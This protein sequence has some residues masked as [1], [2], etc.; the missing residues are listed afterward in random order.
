MPSCPSF[1]ARRPFGHGRGAEAFRARVEKD[2]KL[3]H[4][5]GEGGR[6][7]LQ[8]APSVLAPVSGAYSSNP[9]ERILALGLPQDR[10]RRR[11]T[12]KHTVP[13]SEGSAHHLASRRP[14]RLLSS[15]SLLRRPRQFGDGRASPPTLTKQTSCPSERD[16][17]WRRQPTRPFLLQLSLLAL[18]PFGRLIK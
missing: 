13:L 10:M 11:T 7:E 14:S 15:H 18:E 4:T 1:L 3:A 6:T 12:S 2:L 9:I 16:V 17:E 8:P 5:L